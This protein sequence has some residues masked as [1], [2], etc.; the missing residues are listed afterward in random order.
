MEIGNNCLKSLDEAEYDQTWEL[1]LK[2]QQ[3]MQKLSEMTAGDLSPVETIPEPIRTYKYEIERTVE[4]TIMQQGIFGDVTSITFEGDIWHITVWLC[5]SLNVD[6]FD[7][8]EPL[9]YTIAG[10]TP[11]IMRHVNHIIHTFKF[12]PTDKVNW[13]EEGF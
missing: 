1:S 8:D 6:P 3:L 10:T 2:S 12:G 11:Q 9:Y 7:D 13:R 4:N 5:W